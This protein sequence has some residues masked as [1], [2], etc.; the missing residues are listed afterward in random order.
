MLERIREYERFGQALTN[1]CAESSA[2]MPQVKPSCEAIE[3]AAQGML[4]DI[5]RLDS[6]T[7]GFTMDRE[8]KKGVKEL[9]EYWDQALAATS[10][11]VKADKY[12]RVRKMGAIKGDAVFLKL[13]EEGGFRRPGR[14]GLRRQGPRDVPPDHAA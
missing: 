14:H 12:D 3:A 2:R 8:Q 13:L 4:K 7:F 6:T 10:E 11:D 9:I 1:F 5:G